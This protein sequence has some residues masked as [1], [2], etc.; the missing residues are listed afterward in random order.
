[1]SDE[2]CY[3]RVAVHADISREDV[4]GDIELTDEEL[5]AVIEII[6]LRPD[7]QYG[8]YERHL[9]HGVLHLQHE[10]PM[11]E[12]ATALD[13][14]I[15]TARDTG[16]PILKRIYSYAYQ[17]DSE[18]FGEDRIPVPWEDDENDED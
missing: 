6:Y 15:D 2:E 12:F 17:N 16:H 4:P 5:D 14:A 11:D 10:W 3:R 18:E 9:G 13:H 1:M 7:D 8:V